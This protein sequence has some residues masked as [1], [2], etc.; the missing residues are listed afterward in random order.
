M[1]HAEQQQQKNMSRIFFNWFDGNK[2]DAAKMVNELDKLGVFNI[3]Q[4]TIFYFYVGCEEAPY[5]PTPLELENF[6][7]FV[8]GALMGHYS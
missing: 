2:K 1:S 6:R 4:K 3:G 5:S 7:C 8:Y